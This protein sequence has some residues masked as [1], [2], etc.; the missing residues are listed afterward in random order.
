MPDEVLRQARQEMKS[1]ARTCS[2][3]QSWHPQNEAT[4]SF[5]N[6]AI[7]RLILKADLTSPADRSPYTSHE[8]QR[9]SD[10]RSLPATLQD[11]QD[12]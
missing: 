6:G 10:H 2:K 8:S 11:S 12:A 1:K 7:S 9:P 3:T 5:A 4:S